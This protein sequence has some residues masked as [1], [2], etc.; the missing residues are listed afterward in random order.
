MVSVCVLSYN[1][2]N[3]IRQC[4]DGI[5]MQEVSFPIEVIIHDDASTDKSQ[6][7]I[8][9]Y[10]QKY[11]DIVKPIFQKENQYSKR[12]SI[13]GHFLFPKCTGKYVALCEGDDY[14][15]DPLK[16]QKQVDFMESHP[17]YS[18]CCHRF[19]I[20][21]QNKNIYRQEYAHAYYQDGKN[22]EITENLF[23]NVWVTMT[24]T[25]LYRRDAAEKAISTC[26]EKYHDT[27]DVYL[28][29]EL[30]QLAKGISLNQ[31]MGVY[32]WHDKGVAIGQDSVSRYKNGV[33]TYAKIYEQHQ[34]DKLLL[35][36]IRYNYNRYLRFITVSKEGNA[37]LKTSFVYC[38][39][40]LQRIQMI[41]TY[42]I[43]PILFVISNKIF[44]YYWRKKCSISN[45][46]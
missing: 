2:E 35:P 5:M 46:Y 36:K 24:L 4:L 3:Y 37:S 1:H 20:Y 28:F 23:L 42:L 13:V 27:K 26:L 33:D 32:R 40:I 16:L 6:Q 43:P 15:T 14:W 45:P 9:E 30:L 19:V 39:T 25:S 41:T 44:K 11:P 31:N 17:E 21:E 12:K 34:N 29:Y 8:Q 18:F 22:L 10:V 38:E 7:I